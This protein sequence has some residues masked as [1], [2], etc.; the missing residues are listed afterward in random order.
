MHNYST[1]SLLAESSIVFDTEFFAGV[2]CH[3]MRERYCF[4]VKDSAFMLYRT[5]LQIACIFFLIPVFTIY[6][7]EPYSPQIADKSLEGEQA[8]HRFKIPGGIT[9]QLF[10]AEPMVANPVAFCFDERGRVFVAET[11][12]QSKGVEDNRGHMN[13]LLDDLSARSVADRIEFFKKY[14]KDDVHKY[15][16]EHDRIR[17][18][19]DTDGDGQ[20]DSSTVFADGFNSIEEG[21]GAGLLAIDG[22]VYYTCIPKLWYMKDTDDDGVADDRTALFDGFG[23]RVAFRGHDLHGLV[24][25]PDGRLYFSIG[26][27]GYNVVLKDNSRLVQPDQGAVFRCELDGSKLEVFCTGLR[28]PQELAFDDFGNL[29]TCD[30]NSDGGDRARWTYLVEGSDTGWRMYYQYLADR[31]PWNREK[32]WHTPHAGQAAYIVPPIAHFA[33]GPSGLTHYPGTGLDEKYRGH[34]FLADFRGQAANSGIRT[35]SMI[36][37]GAS[38]ELVNSEEFIWSILATDVDFGY[39]GGVYVSD[40]VDG[41]DGIGKGRIYRF[42]DNL[43][44]QSAMV[45]EVGELMRAGF[46][47]SSTEQL[48]QRLGHPDARIRQRAQLALA[49]KNATKE[50]TDAATSGE[51]LDTRLHGIWGLGQI[52]RR[53]SAVLKPLIALLSDPNPEVRAQIA[54]VFGDSAYGEAAEGL[55]RLIKDTDP[56]VRTLAAIAVGKLKYSPAFATLLEALAENVDADPTLRHGLVMGLVGTA[57]PDQLVATTHIPIPAVRLGAVV[58]LRRLAHPALAIFLKDSDPLVVIEAARAIHDVPVPEALPALA[59][60]LQQP[61]LDE[62]VLR[63][64]LSSNYQ[65]GTMDHADSVAAFAGNPLTDGRLRVEALVELNDWNAPGPLDRVTNEYRPLGTREIDIAAVCQ[66]WLASFF[67]ASPDVREAA[68]KLSSQHRLADAQPYLCEILGEGESSPASL[69]VLA[70]TALSSL[71]SPELLKSIEAALQ[72]KEA[73]VRSEARRILADLDP[74]R[75]VASLAKTMEV[76]PVFEQQAAVSILAA[77]KRPDAD[78]VLSSWFDKLLAGKIIPEV[79]L[80]LLNAAVQRGTPPLLAKVKA[81]D[82]SRKAN[83]HLKDFREAISGGNAERGREIFFAR[84]DVSCRR[85]HKIDGSGGDVG[86]NLSRIG[87]DKNREYLLE[88]IVD[89]NKQIAKGYETA[90]IATSDGKVYAGIVKGDDNEKLT[91]Q[92]ADGQIITIDSS[93]I[94]DRAN[95]KSGMPEDIVKKL[96]KFEIRDVVEYLSSLK[97]A[98]KPDA[99]G[100]Q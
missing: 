58:A 28:N 10:A 41:W 3:Q 50:L 29:F 100:K 30:N 69:R 86:P 97:D 2:R 20:A 55:T 38:F 79:H 49:A 52:G 65:L 80:D 54:R 25:G 43:H 84:T 60:L 23:V 73:A 78:A 17:R 88:S 31:G 77:M 8:I 16:I 40:W 12:R 45:K 74:A 32:L 46:D 92:Q 24:L 68:T 4:F 9:A 7:K 26:D 19:V 13:W 6:A 99:H 42:R 93:T 47:S 57:T 22:G 62:S 59:A 82:K 96:T 56:R 14:Q 27:R 35:F 63:R 83:D 5:F 44:G 98:G 11:F 15:G 48:V 87:L 51:T 91:L 70:L 66:P 75:A 1:I 64:A 36:P 34:F 53:D 71:K 72:D 94:E 67:A 21:T 76:A 81:F 85:C 33:D 90:V 18:L 37:K 39:D 61:G 95:G 89:P